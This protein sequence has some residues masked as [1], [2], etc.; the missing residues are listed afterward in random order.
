MAFVIQP[1]MVTNTRQQSENKYLRKV[2]EV[3][4]KQSDQ[5]QNTH[6]KSLTVEPVRFSK[7]I[8]VDSSECVLLMI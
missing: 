4:T 8:N 6:Q 1:A 7:I 3:K 5:R 2:K